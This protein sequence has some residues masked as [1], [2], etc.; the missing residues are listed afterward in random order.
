M[1]EEAKTLSIQARKLAPAERRE[2]VD[3]IRASLDERLN[4]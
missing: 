4:P 3:S 2:L 1:T